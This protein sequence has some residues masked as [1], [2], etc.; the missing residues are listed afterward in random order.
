MFRRWAR[1]LGFRRYF[2]FFVG[3]VGFGGVFVFCWVRWWGGG[4]FVFLDDISTPYLPSSASPAAMCFI[5]KYETF[6]FSSCHLSGRF[7]FVS[8]VWLHLGGV[9]FSCIYRL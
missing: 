8:F 5:A 6:C 4:Y 1:P 3:F 9:V 2:V 7:L